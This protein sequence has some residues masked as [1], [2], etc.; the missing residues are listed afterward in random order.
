MI[1]LVAGAMVAE[2]GGVKGC[3]INLGL[4][5]RLILYLFNGF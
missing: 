1:E 3:E 2:E 5:V 4:R